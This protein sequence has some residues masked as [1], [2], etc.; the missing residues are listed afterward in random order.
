MWHLTYRSFDAQWSSF[1]LLKFHPL[2]GK[3][4]SFLITFLIYNKESFGGGSRRKENRSHLIAF[5]CP[6]HLVILCMKVLLRY[7]IASD[8]GQNSGDSPRPGDTSEHVHACSWLGWVSKLPGFW[9]FWLVG[10]YL[11]SF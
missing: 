1:E 5:K 7:T 10:F 2:F 3:R 8:K 9:D 11:F 4:I 6:Q